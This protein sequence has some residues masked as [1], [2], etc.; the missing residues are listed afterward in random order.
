MQTH[1]VPGT[2]YFWGLMK[3]PEW[4]EVKDVPRFEVG[5]TSEIEYPHR[6]G[7]TLVI[8]LF[9]G[10]ALIIGE[11]MKRAVSDAEVTA[12]LERAVSSEAYRIPEPSDWEMEEHGFDAEGTAM[13]PIGEW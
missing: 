13:R 3:Y 1:D 2:D 5:S 6:W 10:W 9:F 12:H 4:V 11:W 7:N 8:R